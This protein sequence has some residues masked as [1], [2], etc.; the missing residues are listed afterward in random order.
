MLKYLILSFL[1]LGILSCSNQP[2]LISNS[3]R[4]A[5]IQH[6]L[7]V[8][9]QLTARASLDVWEIFKQP[10]TDNERQAMEFLYA[11]MPLSDL[12]DYPADFFLA[13]VRKSLQARD[14]MAWGKD[15]PEDVFLHFVLPVRINNENLDS[16][17]IVMYDEIKAR[18]EGM[19]I[20]QAALEVN[21]WCHEKVVYRGTDER[22]SAPLST[23]R[24]AFG[25][26]GEEST[27]TVSALRAAGIPARQVYT[28]RW[29]H[30]DDN[31]AWVEVWV[32]GV[33]KFM[34]A[35]EPDARLNMGWF[36]EPARRTL[37]VHTRAYG[38]YFGDEDVVVNEDRFSE[39]NLTSNYAPVKRIIVEVKDAHGQPVTDAKVEFQ[40]YNYAEYYPIATQ[41]TNIAGQASISMGLGEIV[42]WASRD[43]QFAF[44]K[45][46][47]SDTDT[48][49]LTLERPVLNGQSFEFDFVPPHLVK[50]TLTITQAEKE[51]NE[52]RL[53]V[54]DSIRSCYTATFKDET[55]SRQLAVELGLPEEDVVRAI[56]LSYGNWPE[57]ETYFRENASEKHVV[58]LLKGISE[59]D[60]SDTK[61]SILAS[62]LKNTE[63]TGRY[64]DDIFLK[65][66]LAP[67]VR[68]EMLLDWRPAMQ[69]AFAELKN[70]IESDPQVLTNWMKENIHLD[71]IANKHSRAPL[72]PAAVYKLRVAD[73]PSRN[74]F[75]VS[76]CRALG[77]AS[78]LNPATLEP[79]FYADGEWFRAA[80]SESIQA[81]PEIGKLVL[82][83]GTNTIEPQYYIHFTIGK[84]IEGNY[85]TLEYDFAAKISDFEVPLTLETGD[86]CLV[87]GNRLED[88]TVL[89][90][91]EFFTVHAEQTH[92]LTVTLRQSAN[93]PEPIAKLNFSGLRILQ[94]GA[95][96]TLEQ[97]VDGKSLVLALLDPDKEP[98][99][100][101]LND[102]AD[103]V[104]HFETWSGQF[105]FVAAADRQQLGAVLDSYRLPANQLRGFDPDD[106]LLHELMNLFG[107]EV[108]NKLPLVLL[109][110][111]DGNV[112]L[113]SSGYKIGI[114]EQLL[115]IIPVMGK[116]STGSC[117]KS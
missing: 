15:I 88:G 58:A 56:Q 92:A 22:T 29:A 28:P 73:T 31:H 34:G 3:E 13:N 98:S 21:H 114:G 74:I 102:L 2:A 79:E 30:S 65:Y 99:K 23:I 104:S 40:L 52:R 72:S 66:V 43:E 51:L 78:R 94:N 47:I 14:E 86:Y 50:D 83:N 110:D 4:L 9:K 25:R 35:C 71:E 54:E 33:W 95:T 113:F 19:D 89:S 64:P 103:Y 7:E 106:N 62:H 82:K 26:C 116:G 1:L 77:I 46:S 24:K 38:K 93:V 45:I 76:V 87:T 37:L 60:F 107:E 69:H 27:F 20:E 53:T 36:T 84:L 91:T 96:V 85:R 68:N 11:Y 97:L 109:T 12:A 57:L 70:Q 67:R 49:K 75:F 6:M 105:L 39:L 18:V 32:N 16:F 108:K 61:A 10:L 41:Y 90:S 117:S 8:Q 48:V 101:I 81:Q 80:F 42:V 44:Q 100:H 63:D 55:W 112:Y 115:K 5:D 59:K 17:R 111:S